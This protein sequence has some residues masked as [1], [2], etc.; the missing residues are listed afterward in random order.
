MISSSN[1]L[2]SRCLQ[3]AF[4]LELKWNQNRIPLLVISCNVEAQ[5]KTEKSIKE[6]RPRA[7][8]LL[9]PGVDSKKK[10]D[11]ID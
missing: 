7:D 6:R 3:I 4:Q 8:F 1:S 2:Y 9:I 10:I 11:S 5:T